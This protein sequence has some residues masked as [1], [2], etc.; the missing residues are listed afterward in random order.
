LI[1]V[2]ECRCTRLVFLDGLCEGRGKCAGGTLLKVGGPRED[3]R[4]L[5]EGGEL[6]SDGLFLLLVDLLL[7]LGLVLTSL[8]GVLLALRARKRLARLGDVLHE[9][10]ETAEP[11]IKVLVVVREKEER[12]VARVYLKG[13]SFARLLAVERRVDGDGCPEGA[14]LA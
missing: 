12:P 14:T 3:D 7:D 2:D 13:S 10:D 8:L 6:P 5:G 1:S 9:L 4:V 11:V